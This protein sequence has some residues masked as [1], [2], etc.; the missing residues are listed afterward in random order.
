MALN[1]IKVLFV[2]DTFV[3]RI[4]GVV[5]FITEVTKRLS[6][7]FEISFLAPK[8]YGSEL[9]AKKLKGKVFF[10]P[11]RKFSIEDFPLTY[12]ESK[13]IE[14]AIDQ[15]D[16]V[17]INSI[18]PLGASALSHAHSVGK[19]V[20]AYIHAIDWELLAYATNFPRRA[21]NLLK[22]AIRRIYGKADLL[23]VADQKVKGI[24]EKNRIKG[25]FEVIRLGVDLKAFKP[26]SRTR[27]QM[28][29]KL[30]LSDNF[31]VGFHGRLSREK[32][33]DM[34]YKA[35]KLVKIHIPNAKLLVIGDGPER[36]VLSK[37]KNIILTGFVP[38]PEKYL[39]AMDV[40][41]LPSK[42]ETTGLSLMEAMACGL[43]VISSAVGMIPTYV[44]SGKN[45]ILIKP[46]DLSA[47]ILA[48][49]VRTVHDNEVS[50]TL[51]KREAHRTVSKFYGWDATVSKL[52]QVFKR[53]YAK[54]SK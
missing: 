19:P 36:K 46:K 24:L 9:A 31:V 7:L 15:A 53:I 2:S 43:P 51:M 5:R 34:L 33:I 42:T 37:N 54:N 6:P 3:P 45:G 12:P 18:A 27:E 8:L 17:F 1:K 16:I 22:P 4:D 39:R 35:F 29:E 10:C 28:R 47:A 49:S 41:V 21:V 11:T 44:K 25:P 48:K 30:G 52:E 40:Y 13:T 14:S 50:T 20:V 26:E 32:N 38:N 23:L